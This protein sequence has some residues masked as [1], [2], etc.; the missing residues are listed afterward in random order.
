M[1]KNKRQLELEKQKARENST[2]VREAA[3]QNAP[4]PTD[5]AGMKREADS[6]SQAAGNIALVAILQLL[7]MAQ[8]LALLQDAANALPQP[9][10]PQA[11]APVAA[12]TVRAPETDN[13]QAS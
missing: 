11:V 6:L 8:R 1:S 3:L 2:A 10:A 12:E 9:A 13:V 5:F 7:P 4:L